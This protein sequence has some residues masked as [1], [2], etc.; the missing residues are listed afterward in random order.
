MAIRPTQILM[1]DT[2]A[3]LA[4]IPTDNVLPLCFVNE[5]SRT[6]RKVGAEWKLPPIIGPELRGGAVST[7]AILIAGASIDLTVT[8]AEPFPANVTNIQAVAVVASNLAAN[9]LGSLSINVKSKSLTGAVVTLKN[10]GLIG[11]ASGCVIDVI[12]IGS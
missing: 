12:A 9:L 3:E 5:N 1:C 7:N 2:V 8:F 11:L 6:Y 4:Q 10:S